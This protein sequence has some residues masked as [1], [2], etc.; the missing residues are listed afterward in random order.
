MAHRL[1]AGAI[2][3][4][5]L[6]VAT[7][8]SRSKESARINT[9]AI[10]PARSRRQWKSGR[11]RANYLVGGVVA[12]AAVGALAVLVLV[13][14]GTVSPHDRLP[15]QKTDQNWDVVGT[16][17][18]P[19]SGAFCR[20]LALDNRTGGISDLGWVRCTGV[21]VDRMQVPALQSTAGA[22]A[23]VRRSFANRQ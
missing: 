20:Q 15:A 22:A 8:A 1:G 10:G 21:G 11:S 13:L 2:T 18:L 16:I 12:F 6:V 9:V 19:P 17:T 5:D 4:R 23:D 14:S 3:I 7:V